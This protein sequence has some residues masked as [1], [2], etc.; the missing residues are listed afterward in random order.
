MPREITA[1]QYR[2]GSEIGDGYDE[3]WLDLDGQRIEVWDVGCEHDAYGNVWLTT[4][5]GDIRVT[6]NTTLTVK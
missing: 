3:V 2:T 5:R 4:T 6:P 1:E